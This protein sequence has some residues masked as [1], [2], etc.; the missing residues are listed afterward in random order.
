MKKLKKRSLSSREETFAL[1]SIF[2]TCYNE[3]NCT[4]LLCDCPTTP[5]HQ[6]GLN[7]ESSKK[8]RIDL[9]QVDNALDFGTD[10]YV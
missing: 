9:R 8:T 4:P 2:C 7:Q 6:V 3:C 5:T 1:S 10:A